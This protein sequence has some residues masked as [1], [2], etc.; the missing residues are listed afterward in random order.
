MHWKFRLNN[1]GLRQSVVRM[2]MS[3]THHL[4]QEYASARLLLF[5]LCVCVHLSEVCLCVSIYVCSV[6]MSRTVYF[7][8]FYSL[9]ATSPRPASALASQ[10]IMDLNKELVGCE[11]TL[12]YINFACRRV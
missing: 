1:A 7:L 2:Q 6:T 4:F 10:S 9:L 5:I 11:K 12:V 8:V 3:M